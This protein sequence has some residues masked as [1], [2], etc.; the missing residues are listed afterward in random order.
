M[1]ADKSEKNGVSTHHTQS[2]TVGTSEELKLGPHFAD[3]ENRAN[4]H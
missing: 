1:I 3:R 2:S 4:S